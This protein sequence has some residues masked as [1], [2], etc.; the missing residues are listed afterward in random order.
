MSRCKLCKGQTYWIHP[1]DPD[2]CGCEPEMETRLD[3]RDLDYEYLE[4]DQ[5]W[6]KVIS[7][8][9]RVARKDHK[10]GEVM[11]GERYTEI[12]WSGLFV[13]SPATSTSREPSEG[14]GD[15][16]LPPFWGGLL[17]GRVFPEPQCRSL[18]HAG[19]PHAL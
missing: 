4:V 6:R 1:N 12:V 2:N 7:Y 5:A 19:N 3:L 15:G 18:Q 16:T 10:S 11:K 14:D 8:A 13:T 9:Q 17:R